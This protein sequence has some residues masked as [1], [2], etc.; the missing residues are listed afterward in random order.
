M[1]APRS[2]KT[3]GL[4]LA[5]FGALLLTP[6]TLFMRLSQLDGFNMLLWR[7]GLS[8]LAY[9]MIW[10]WMRGP[11]DLSNIWTRN[12]AIIVACQTGNAALFSLAI[13][14]APV[15]VVLI[16]VA[17][18][19]IFAALLSR[20]LLGEAL[21]MRTLITAAMV[22]LG[23]FISVL[24]SDDG[25]L[26]LDLTTLIGA[27][28]GL[29]VAFSLAMNFTIIRKD[30]DVPF[31]L[32]IAVGAIAAAGLAAVFATTLA[33]P[34][35]P[36]MAAIALTG[37]FILPLSFVTLSYAARF[38]PSSTVSLIMLL[39][40]VLGPLWVWWG[41]GEAPSAMMLIGGGIVLTCLSVFLILEG[42]KAA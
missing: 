26:M 7:G 37:I 21:S 15:I 3:I 23:L 10:L 20:L 22:F 17:T 24:G 11:R 35:L 4:T 13:A 12:F 18:V 19:P 5:I 16:G 1:T 27:G 8:G 6:D 36:Q 31:V 32:A 14:L 40:T 25:H 33:W 9:F 2:Q 38:V 39:E 42:R 41:I 34:P 28:L 30:T 29:G